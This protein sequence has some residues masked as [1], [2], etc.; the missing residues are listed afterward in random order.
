MSEAYERKRP[1]LNLSLAPQSCVL[2]QRV[3]NQGRYLDAVLADREL[4][5][6]SALAAVSTGGWS[7]DHVFAAREAFGKLARGGSRRPPEL[8]ALLRAGA[9]GAVES[10]GVP[11]ARWQALVRACQEDPQLAVDLLEIGL[12]MDAGNQDVPAALAKALPQGG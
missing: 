5:W 6:R 1:R 7:V 9:L 10:W 4:R 12:E 8:L 3:A 2:L 11:L